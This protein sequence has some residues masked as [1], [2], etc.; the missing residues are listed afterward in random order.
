MQRSRSPDERSDIRGNSLGTPAPDI[1]ALHPGYDSF[2]HP[3]TPLF[4]NTKHAPPALRMR[5]QR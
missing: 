5:L 2:P 4:F 3:G 1:A